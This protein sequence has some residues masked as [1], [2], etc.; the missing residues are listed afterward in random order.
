MSTQAAPWLGLVKTGTSSQNSDTIFLGTLTFSMDLRA[1]TDG[2]PVG[3]L[4]YY[5]VTSPADAVTY[6]TTPLTALNNP[7]VAADMTGLGQSPT[8]GATVNSVWAANTVWFKAGEP[9]YS[10]FSDQSIGTYQFNVSS[11]AMGSY[12]FTPV[13]TVLAY[14]SVEINT[15]ATPGSFELI[16]VPEPGTWTLL[17]CG[18]LMAAWRN[19][20]RSSR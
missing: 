10:A 15:F 9:D 16:V 3:A 8:A 14:G 6:G 19:R 5:I 13:G 4:E 11:L 2:N 18:G 20:R 7:F 12:V 1:N 17:A